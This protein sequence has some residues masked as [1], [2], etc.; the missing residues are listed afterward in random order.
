MEPFCEMDYRISVIVPVYR[1]EKYISR[2]CRSLFGTTSNSVEFIFVDDATPDRSVDVIQSVMNQYPERKKHVRILRHEKNLGVACARNTGLEAAKGEYIAFVDADDWV[3]DD[4]FEKM[5]RK[6]VEDKLDVVGC[7]W[8]V[9]F[10][11]NRRYMRQP[12]LE[13]AR[14]GLLAMLAGGLRWFLW[15]FLV[16]HELYTRNEIRFVEGGNIG[17]DMAVL[18]QCFAFAE[19]YGHISEP[20]YH[21]IR[22]N[23]MSMTQ[24]DQKRQ[25]AMVRLNVDVVEKFLNKR[26]HNQLERELDFLKLNVKFPLLITD[27][28]DNYRL[29]NQY[30]TEANRSIWKNGR[31]P[32]RNKLLQYAAM[33][34]WYW[35]LKAYY[36]I[37]FKFVYGVL[38]K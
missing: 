36:R 28:T 38:Y 22:G 24:L 19:S 9:E 20:L 30:F 17:E 4:I 12:V 26:Y 37:F 8:Y 32:L 6:A 2:C 21:Y 1:V 5:Y 33:H 13:S 27:D 16:R 7:D 31:Q 34:H 35:F 15:A 14:Q 3:E 23:V 18:I 29:W 11:T 25:F 10:K